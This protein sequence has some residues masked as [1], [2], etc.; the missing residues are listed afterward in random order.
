MASTSASAGNFGQA[1]T[2]SDGTA[3]IVTGDAYSAGNR[4]KTDVEQNV[5]ANGGALNLQ[6]QAALVANVGLAPGQQ[7][8]QHRHGQH[9][10][11][12]RHRRPRT[13]TLT[14]DPGIDLGVVGQ[15]G[16]AS[17]SSDGTAA[18]ETGTASAVGNDER[19]RASARPS[20]RRA[21]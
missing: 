2:V 20:T 3:S 17:S 11:Q 9:L 16:K 21:S 14:D 18:I 12:R 19:D 4:S 6:T 1:E 15:F 5:E 10:E 7:R 13:P 8:R